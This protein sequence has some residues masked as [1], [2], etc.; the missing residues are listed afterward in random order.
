MLDNFSVIFGGSGN[1]PFIDI[2]VGDSTYNLLSFLDNEN[3]LNMLLW[4]KNIIG[5]YFI[6]NI[7]VNIIGGLPHIIR[8]KMN[9]VNNGASD[10]FNANVD[11]WGWNL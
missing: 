5:V 7:I 4:L 10:A 11:G 3:I 6:L 8:G 1:V 2:T 9:L